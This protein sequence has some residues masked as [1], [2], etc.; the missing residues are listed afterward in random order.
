M[1]V[2]VFIIV[3]SVALFLYW[4]RYTCLLI[5]SARTS[6]DY[7]KQVAAANQ[8]SFLQAS[9]ALDD[10]EESQ[11]ARIHHLLDRDYKRLTYLLNYGANSYQSGKT[12]ETRILMI[13][14]W[15]MWMWCMA[16]HRLA[17]D[18][19]RGALVEMSSI[20]RHLANAMGEQLAISSTNQV[21]TL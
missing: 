16:M 19:A 8:L 20:I 4:F 9:Q 5:L 18:R 13:D 1:F 21:S 17:P 12:I 15:L 6:R 2:S 3:V 11:L 14:Y 7:A 10:A